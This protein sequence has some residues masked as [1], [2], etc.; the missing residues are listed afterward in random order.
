VLAAVACAA[1]AFTF[2]ARYAEAH[3]S[4]VVPLTG[5][6][7]TFVDGL[8]PDAHPVPARLRA[9]LGRPSR[10]ERGPGG[11]TCR[12]RWRS[13]GVTVLLFRVGSQPRGACETGVFSY[14]RLTGRRWHTT[15]GVR[16][17]APEGVARRAAL[18]HCPGRRRCHLRKYTLSLHHSDCAGALVPTVVA[19]VRRGRVRTLQ[20]NSL[21]CE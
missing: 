3:R 2:Y 4:F 8:D 15:S 1:C 17:G 16:P 13:H 12:M 7:G 6:F 19:E 10:V 14:A 9:A 20:V 21:G 11:A 18:R 5:G